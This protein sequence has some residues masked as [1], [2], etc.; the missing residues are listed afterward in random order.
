MSN[1]ATQSASAA[2]VGRKAKKAGRPWT[3]YVLATLFTLYVL[4]LYGP[5]LCIYILS[6]QDF[7]GGLVFPMKGLSTHWFVD[8]FTQ[9]RTGDVKG[10]FQRSISLAVVVTILTVVISFFAGL[11]FRRKFKGSSLLFYIVIGSL[12]TPGLILGIGIGLMFQTF[13]IPPAWYSSALGAHLSWTLPFGVL[14]MFAVF[15]RFDSAWEEAAIDLGAKKTQII[16]MVIAPIL[17]PGLIAV[18]LFG[19]TLSY[20]EFSRSQQTSGALNTLPLEIWGMT[21]NVTS[22]GLYALGTVTTIISFI[23]IGAS[24]YSIVLIQKKRKEAA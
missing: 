9:V 14:I 21:Q 10:G 6:F 23:V 11:G 7:R 22:P 24:L 16:R 8:L 4:F 18:A 2:P 13:G 12:V 3:F 19:F 5:M 20:D 1:S 17:A 15:S